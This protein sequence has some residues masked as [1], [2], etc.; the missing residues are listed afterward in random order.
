MIRAPQNG[1]RLLIV[2]HYG[3]SNTGDELMLESILESLPDSARVAV[4][5]KR[6][7]PEIA[8]RRNVVFVNKTLIAVLRAL[9]SADTV[10]LGGGTHFHDDYRGVRLL[11]HYRYMA[12]YVL[13]F[14]LAKLLRKRVY[15][16]GMGIGPFA[17]WSTR[18]LTRC[19]FALADG[20]SVRDAASLNEAAMLGAGQKTVRAFDLTGLMG[21]SASRNTTA[22]D[23]RYLAISVTDIHGSEGRALKRDKFIDIL[24]P[25]L[26]IL[27]S[28]RPGIHVKVIVV[29]GGE[30]ESDTEMSN[31]LLRQLGEFADRVTL[32]PYSSDRE[33]LFREFRTSWAACVM[34]YHAGMLAYLAGCRLLLLPYH[35]KLTDLGQ[36]LGLPDSACPSLQ[37]LTAER[38]ARLLSD[39][40]NSDQEFVPKLPVSVAKDMALKNFAFLNP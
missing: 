14:A 1:E 38:L 20:I 35:R 8:T 39:L 33:A 6:E 17:L 22:A 16:I 12:R 13:V 4:V 2:G 11:R 24:V 29:R 25:A 3:G 36:E 19:A 28:A 7:L 37:R 5:A 30:R 40:M 31:L 34:R 9:R 18:L 32:V 23:P 21:S 10:L 15:C 26:G 27:L